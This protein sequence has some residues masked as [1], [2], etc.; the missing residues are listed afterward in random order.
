MR[1]R[2][3]TS[4]SRRN[5]R[6]PAT[7]RRPSPRI[8]SAR[9]YVQV[10][11][12][13]QPPR[14]GL[15]KKLAEDKGLPCSF[16]RPKTRFAEVEDEGLKSLVQQARLGT[17]EDAKRAITER[18]AELAK[19]ATPP[20]AQARAGETWFINY[21]PEDKDLG[22]RAFNR[23][24]ERFECIKPPLG[25]AS[26][27]DLRAYFAEKL[28]ECDH[29][30]MVYGKASRLSVNE[31]VRSCFKI[32]TSKR[33]VDSAIAEWFVVV[34]PPQPPDADV[35]LDVGCRGF[36][37]HAV[38]CREDFETR[39]TGPFSISCREGSDESETAHH[40]LSAAQRHRK[41]VSW[42]AS[43]QE[44]GIAD[45][46]RPRSASRPVARV[47]PPRAF[48]G[49]CRFLR[50]WQVV[51]GQGGPVSGVTCGAVA[52]RARAVG[53]CGPFSGLGVLTLVHR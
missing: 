4:C 47:A 15:Q 22:L 33:P 29:L 48:P 36:R 24:T 18:L 44:N 2:R 50:L 31:Q 25:G 21:L 14:Q 53:G 8:S 52:L 35:E 41:P 45:F 38:D 40:E 34:G 11:G 43:V 49:R 46:L 20:N 16:G 30:V 10:V 5:C 6:P 12:Y 51:A 1:S 28:L 32:V 9:L 42:L 19:P 23:L 7:I 37:L 27:A 17:V 39:S 13:G 26:E 3:S